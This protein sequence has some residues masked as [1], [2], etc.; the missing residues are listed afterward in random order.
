MQLFSRN[1]T[2]VALSLGALVALGAC[3]D[4]V[5][6]TETPPP[7][8]VSITPQSASM[9]VGESLNFA[10]LISGGS[11][12]A[13]PTLASCTSSNTAVATATAAGSACRVTAV[14]A[15]NA[16]V[17]AATSTGKAAAAS[18]TVAAP[19]AAINTLTVS[20]TS[21]SLAVNQTV[22][23]VPNV[24]KAASSVTTTNSFT[25]SNT[26]IA[27]VTSAG[28]VT[29][30]APGVATITVSVQ[31]SGTGYTTTTLT[32]AATV[33]VT[34]LP[35]G[36]TALNVQPSSLVMGLLTTAQLSASVQQPAGAAAATITYGTTAPAVATVSST[37]LVTAVSSGTAVITV[38]A[39][40]AANTNF[41][42]STLTQQVP[43]T[44]SPSANVT[45][46]T[47][48]QGP[49][50]TYYST[51]SGAE[52]LVTSANAQVNQPVDI[53]NVR[54]QIQV[55]L[56]LQPNGQRVD[57]V[58][59]FI[60]NADG[61]N[62]RPAARQLYSNGT[63]NQ[64]DITLFVNTADFTANFETGA[65]DVF[66]PNGQK[67]ISASVFTTQ[68]TT[69]VEQQNAVNNRQTLNFNNL[70]GYAARY[71]NPSRSAIHASNNLTWWG[72]P[73]AEGTGTYSIVPVFYTPG[74]T[75]TRIDIGLREGLNGSSAICNQSGQADRTLA[76]GVSNVDPLKTGE[77]T[78]Y[79]RYTALP[80]N[81]S[82][83]SEVGRMTSSSSNT[84][85]NFS[86]AA[87][88]VI[89]CRGYSHPASDA[90]NFV[91]VV[92]GT[93]NYNNPAPVVTRVDGY[94][95]SA[96]VARIQANRLD[97][98]GPTTREPD[99]RRTAPTTTVAQNAIW[100]TPAVTGWVNAA[101]NFQSQTASSSDNGI[102]LP[103]TSS[104]AWRFFGCAA[105]TGG[106]AASI[107]TASAAM[108][109]ATGADIPECS[110]DN[111]GG[112]NPSAT[113]AG[114]YNLK[115]RGP[116]TVAYTETDVLGNL[117]YSPLSQRLG[118]DKTA[119]L[120]RFS[121]ASAAD[122]AWGSASRSV[123]AEVIDERAGFI[124]NNDQDAVLRVSASSTY[125]LQP[126][127]YGSFQHFATRGASSAN[128]QT[129]N[130]ASSNNFNC[131]N[132]NSLVA[133]NTS[134]TNPFANTSSTATGG[135][136]P[137]T[138]P[139]CPFI[140]Q[141]NNGFSI[142]IFGALADGYRQATA[143]TFGNPGI[144]AY[145][146]KVYDRAGN[147]SEVLSRAVAIDNGPAPIFGDLNVPASIAAGSAPVFQAQISD[148]VEARAYN[149]S[150]LWPTIGSRFIYPQTLL[151]AR[152]NDEVV[153]PFA[154]N[155][156]LPTGA[157]FITA[158]ETTT[159]TVPSFSNSPAALANIT[160]IQGT[161]FDVNNAASAA[162]TTSFGA[163]ALSNLNS[164]SGVNGN[165]TANNYSSWTVLNTQ[166]SLQPAFL[167][168][169]GLKAQLTGNTNVPNPPFSRVEFFRYNATSGNYEY[170]G[171]ATSAAQSDQGVIR[172]WT[173]TLT[174]DAYAKTPTSLETTQ[175]Q[176]AVNDRIIAIGVR[177]N[178]AGLA[179]D[180]NGI[181]IGGEA[182]AISVTGLPA[183]A[184]ASITISN[185]LGYTQTVTGPG[186]YV[187]PAAGTYFVTGSQVTFNNNSYSVQSVTPSGTVVV[188]A[189]SVGSATVN[190][191]LSTTQVSVTVSGV[192]GGGT[193]SFTIAGPN[194]F[195]QTV[196]QGNGTQNYVVPGAGTYSV[197]PTGSSV[198]NGYT[199]TAPAAVTGL[200][201]ALPPAAV[202]NAALAY[203][204]TTNH[205]QFNVSGLPTGMNLPS[206]AGCGIGSMANGSNHFL[207]GANANCT[208]AG[209]QS[210]FHAPTNSFYTTTFA[211]P[212]AA[213]V[214][215][216]GSGTNGAP[217][218]NV[219]Y[220][221]Q[222]AQITVNLV[223]AGGGSNNLPNGIPFTV[224][225]TSSTYAAT[226]GFQDFNGT[227]GT[228]LVV[229]APPGTYNVSIAIT[230]VSGGQTWT[231]TT[232]NTTATGGTGTNNITTA[233]TNLVVQNIVISGAPAA[234][235]DIQATVN[236]GL[237]GPTGTP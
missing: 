229:S 234:A 34:A 2:L 4:D 82:Y 190:Y 147:V 8:T 72:G 121:T 31:G 175:R 138:N 155:V 230:Q 97:Y 208:L 50:S 57:S 114:D 78:S 151:N 176:V 220:T 207:V 217:A 163:V 193:P 41:A 164:I 22:T 227:T 74:R 222:A 177:S 7:E 215:A 6:V 23:I 195:S 236:F 140:N 213:A 141:G 20:P 17:T 81:G 143:V 35:S 171:Q 30:V 77:G 87:N 137:V 149:L 219:V 218:Y 61:S 68:G 150:L 48:T 221:Q 225:F 126:S 237:T 134:S 91:G 5:T 228:P 96:Q 216:S 49:I 131:I 38:T 179:T 25:S 232:G 36:I 128:P 39:T 174:S 67:L 55:V 65:A 26:A 92:A 119:P 180:P 70:D 203:T 14:A 156:Q 32:G 63:A 133:M 90:S 142:G 27:T 188:N 102:G 73:G 120:I 24:N 44:V 37:G 85:T 56:N 43:V 13:A 47:I 167:A 60:A 105:G 107:D 205:I 145:R 202:P 198:L 192:V 185:G 95:F 122:T 136:N 112:W 139:S 233:G 53:T 12:T 11:A 83:N 152:F 71:T 146:A 144:Y 21:A 211:N 89:E 204:N 182:I 181:V 10:V 93:D 123:Q 187:V 62:R 160:N 45:I 127:V 103:A 168:P 173:W 130:R 191:T 28:V 88:K 16:T 76:L 166:A 19:A 194:G 214:T 183:G 212:Y 69:A 184:A 197:T 106:S 46:Q 59:V 3:G 118:V 161:G 111:Q 186:T 79:E 158:L 200:N 148:D 86:T 235:A 75:V 108:P 172:F 170:L 117:S 109:N 135:S 66:Y 40:S 162:Y 9:N 64:G 210:T 113:A 226:G 154:G 157:P 196:S 94:R 58:V 42:A 110:S 169:A 206:A 100:N 223:T 201:V 54:D 33:T 125:Q 178:G 98:A 165:A 159:G 189:N 124:D 84:Y 18:I 51:S 231:G 115:T 224:R 199:H 52:G 104:R 15:G 132:P 80:F 1:K 101:F 29:A 209:N 129:L 116:Y 153:T 99:I